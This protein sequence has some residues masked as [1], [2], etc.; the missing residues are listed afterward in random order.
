MLEIYFSKKNQLNLKKSSYIKIWEWYLNFTWKYIK[1]FYI[2]N[3]NIL[4]SFKNTNKI[5]KHK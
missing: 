5:L 4:K 2:F 3:I 1:F